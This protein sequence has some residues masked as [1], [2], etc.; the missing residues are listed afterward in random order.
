MRLGKI[1][2][3]SELVFHLVIFPLI[4]DL[5][6]WFNA[7]Y[8]HPANFNIHNFPHVYFFPSCQPHILHAILS[9]LDRSLS[10]PPLSTLISTHCSRPPE[11]RRPGRAGWR[12]TPSQLIR[13]SPRWSLVHLT[14]ISPTD[15][16]EST[17]RHA[18]LPHSHAMGNRHRT[19]LY[20]CVILTS[21]LPGLWMFSTFNIWPLFQIRPGH[22]RQWSLCFPHGRVYLLPALSS[23]QPLLG[24]L[25]GHSLRGGADCLS[26][27]GWHMRPP[28]QSTGRHA[29][30]HALQC[31]RRVDGSRRR[32]CLWWR[33]WAQPQ[34]I[35][36]LGYVRGKLISLIPN[37]DVLSILS[38][39]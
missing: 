15:T 36:L 2:Q 27:R 12:S 28:Q 23:H 38:V 9:S 13:V 7:L 17:S 5:F 18:A 37:P 20:C 34:W 14:S 26:S 11:R 25:P 39:E 6:I 16:V 29:P 31:W 3:N 21:V 4:S 10:F 32:M 35:C 33:L 8:M 1:Q 24:I 30:S 22:R 19:T